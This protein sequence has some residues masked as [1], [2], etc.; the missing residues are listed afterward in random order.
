MLLSPTLDGKRG[1]LDLT[2][3]EA[4]NAVR[5]GETTATA[6]TK[7]SLIAFEAKQAQIAQ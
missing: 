2:L 4:A 5:S 7:A 6:L 3:C 1:L